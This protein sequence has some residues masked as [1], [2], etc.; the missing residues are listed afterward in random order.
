MGRQRAATGA[1]QGQGPGRYYGVGRI[2]YS[3]NRRRLVDTVLGS[4]YDAGCWLARVVLERVQTSTSTASGRLMFQMGLSA[5]PGWVSAP[6][7]DAEY[8]PLPK[9]AG[10]WRLYQPIWQLRLNEHERRTVGLG[11]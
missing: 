2:N 1:G 3:I 9:F 10:F 8:R 11:P 6:N 5:L 7:P 4:R